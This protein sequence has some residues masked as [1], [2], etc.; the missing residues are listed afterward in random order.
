M[1]LSELIR[2]YVDLK[3][4]GPP[5]NSEWQTI[6]NN[7]ARQTEY[8]QRLTELE[9]AIDAASQPPAAATPKESAS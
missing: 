9:D 1:R 4:E 8:H 2:E 7:A 5:E 3:V 6:Y